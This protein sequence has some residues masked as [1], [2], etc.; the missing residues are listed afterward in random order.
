MSE[1]KNVESYRQGRYMHHKSKSTVIFITNEDQVL[2]LSAPLPVNQTH[3]YTEHAR[4]A[5]NTHV[6]DVLLERRVRA[7]SHQ[8]NS[9]HTTFPTNHTNFTRKKS[10]LK[11]G[12]RIF[13]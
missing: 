6:S 9:Y 7:H 12:P 1:S 8:T 13:L 2:T 5:W 3:V 10:L 11:F 4:S